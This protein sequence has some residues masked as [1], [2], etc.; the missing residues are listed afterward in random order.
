[1][2][3]IEKFDPSQLMQGVKDRVRATFVS[4]I[5]DE[6][7]Q[8]MI[9]KEVDD[10]FK[11]TEWSYS[12]SRETRSSFGTICL[13]VLNQLTKEKLIVAMQDYK[14]TLWNSNT[15]QYQMSD[16]LKDLMIKHAPEIFAAT[17]GNMFQQVINSVSN[18][19]YR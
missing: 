13:D 14:S 5:P 17:L 19:N 12:H 11:E 1:M 16:A 9:Q 4:L 6:H 7:W 10:F 3:E 2:T 18:G 15:Q 8:A